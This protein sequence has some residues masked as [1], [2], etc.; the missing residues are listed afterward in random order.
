[1][2]ILVTAA[3]SRDETTLVEVMESCNNNRHF[4]PSVESASSSI[5]ST[6]QAAL[7]TQSIRTSESRTGDLSVALRKMLSLSNNAL[8]QYIVGRRDFLNDPEIC[9]PCWIHR[10]EHSHQLG[11]CMGIALGY[12]NS[13]SKYR[14]WKASFNLQKGQCYRCC[15]PQVS[16]SHVFNFIYFTIFFSDA[17]HP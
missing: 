9:A 14:A 2:S 1:M 8:S 4:P 7:L 17:G 12:Q 16:V 10:Q 11:D 15:L 13:G 6:S 5:P 3:R